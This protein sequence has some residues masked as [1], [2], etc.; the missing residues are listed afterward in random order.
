MRLCTER[1]RFPISTNRDLLSALVIKCYET[2]RY[3]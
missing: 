1:G 3:P 2:I